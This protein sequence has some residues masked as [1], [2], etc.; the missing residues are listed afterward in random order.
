MG[1]KQPQS[2]F[3]I[4]GQVFTVEDKLFVPMMLLHSTIDRNLM[5]NYVQNGASHLY[6]LS[7]LLIISLIMSSCRT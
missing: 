5:L 7:D 6:S 2:P 1:N 4:W 3:E